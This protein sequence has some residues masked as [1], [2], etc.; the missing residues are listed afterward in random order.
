MEPRI[1]H[2]S[3]QRFADV[4]LSHVAVTV[5]TSQRKFA[6]CPADDWHGFV[7]SHEEPVSC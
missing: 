3:W 2:P 6:G 4:P 5:T 7:V 1:V